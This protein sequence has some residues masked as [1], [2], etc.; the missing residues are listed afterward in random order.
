LPGTNCD[1]IAQAVPGTSGQRWQAFLTNRQWDAA[2]RN[3]QRVA[4]M[5]AEATVGDGV[6]ALDDTGF[7]EQGNASVGGARHYS[8]RLG[9]VG[10]CRMA[11]TW[12]YPD[13]QVPGPV[14][15]RLSL[16]QAGADAPKR[17]YA[18]HVPAAITAPTKPA[19]ALALLDQARE[20]GVPSR[21]VGADADY[22]DNPHVL[23]GSGDRQE[24]CVL[25][26][27]RDVRVSVGRVARSPVRRAEARL[28]SMPRWQ[29]RTSRWRQGAK[30]RLR[31]Q[32]VAVRGWRVTA[33]GHRHVGRWVGERATR[34]PPEE[35][36]YHGSRL[37]GPAT[38]EERAG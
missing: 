26:V 7:A 28:Q 27:R 10:N 34:G 12:C 16:P 21:C 1:T 29:W 13:L 14:A 4:K 20:R 8:G 23:A 32:V 31:K 2:D 22:G 24:R 18:A 33:E 6:L 30:G 19:S 15:V 3:R 9:T 11:V 38:L 36:K 5:L 17:R 25:G 37:P 35:R